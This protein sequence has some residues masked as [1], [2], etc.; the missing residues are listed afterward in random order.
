[1]LR[2][3]CNKNVTLCEKRYKTILQGEGYEQKNKVKSAETAFIPYK[4]RV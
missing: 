2:Y 3:I 1:M 4:E